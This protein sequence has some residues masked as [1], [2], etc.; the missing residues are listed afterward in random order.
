MVEAL[1]RRSEK[2]GSVKEPDTF[3]GSDLTNLPNFVIG[4]HLVF[5]NKPRDYPTDVNKINYVLS[6]LRGT[7]LEYFQ[8]ELLSVYEDEDPPAWM[9]SLTAL[10]DKL[11]INFGPTDDAED[12]E[13]K[14]DVLHMGESV[15]KC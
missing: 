5:E 2:K 4:V 3:N 8:P 15:T 9:G 11:T 6:L 7:A 13:D 1:S 10:I 14:L 12:A